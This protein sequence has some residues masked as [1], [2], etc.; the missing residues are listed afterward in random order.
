MG[1][2]SLGLIMES[3]PGEETEVQEEEIDVE[4]YKEQR[5]LL[6]GKIY[7]ASDR[8]TAASKKKDEEAKKKA[9]EEINEIHG[10]LL[11][12]QNELKGKNNEILPEW[13][14]PL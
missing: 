13:W 10:Q 7:E 4:Y 2:T 1:Q 12:L 6:E 9:I 8:F 3:K 11:D 5:A 14:S